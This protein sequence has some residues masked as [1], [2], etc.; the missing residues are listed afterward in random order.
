MEFRPILVL[1]ILLISWIILN[2]YL[3]TKN[4]AIESYKNIIFPS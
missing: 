2:L 3:N 4:P 1:S